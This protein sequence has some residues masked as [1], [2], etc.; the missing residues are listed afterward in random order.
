MIFFLRKFGLSWSLPLPFWWCSYVD[1]RLDNFTWFLQ[2]SNVSLIF[3]CF[4]NIRLLCI[5]FSN[6]VFCEHLRFSWISFGSFFALYDEF[7][8]FRHRFCDFFY[9]FRNSESFCKYG[10]VFFEAFHKSL[11]YILYFPITLLLFFIHFLIQFVFLYSLHTIWQ[12]LQKKLQ[13]FL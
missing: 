8:D 10:F 4:A 2:S 1:T 6:F 11:E 9:S 5:S 12:K 7:L 3:F 13:N